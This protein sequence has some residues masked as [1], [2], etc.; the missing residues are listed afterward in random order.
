MD[1]KTE[2]IKHAFETHEETVSPVSE[3]RSLHSS[4]ADLADVSSISVTSSSGKSNHLPTANMASSVVLSTPTATVMSAGAIGAADIIVADSLV[5]NTRS[6]GAGSRIDQFCD[7]AVV[8]DSLAAHDVVQSQ[9]RPFAALFVG[10]E[11]NQAK[12]SSDS[13]QS[14]SRRSGSSVF[15]VDHSKSSSDSKQPNKRRS[16][17]S[18]F[19]ADSSES[20]SRRSVGQSL[21][22]CNT[23]VIDAAS[24]ANSAVFR[25]PFPVPLG[26]KRSSTGS[27]GSRQSSDNLLDK[28]CNVPADQLNDK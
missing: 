4:S 28:I 22:T 23:V 2:T 13:K 10:S 20:A 25:L 18:L 6:N 27:S 17:S 12:S 5:T 16:S 3:P 7:N 26:A 11:A 9:H 8:H 24:N 19:S 15:S 1:Q 21:Y 14:L